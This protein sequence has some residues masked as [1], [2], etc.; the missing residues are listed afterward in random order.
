MV[1]WSEDLYFFVLRSPRKSH[2][3]SGL[4]SEDLF[5]FI[6]EVAWKITQKQW[7][8]GGKT[9]FFGNHLDNHAKILGRWSEDLF[10][11]EICPGS[12]TE[13]YSNPISRGFNNNNLFYFRQ[14]RSISLKKQNKRKQTKSR[15]TYVQATHLFTDYT[16]RVR[17]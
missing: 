4:L 3:N 17:L 14:L 12:L 16:R 15:G 7:V 2:K 13:K 11:F 8:A 9:F 6:L 1:R 10:F 5:I